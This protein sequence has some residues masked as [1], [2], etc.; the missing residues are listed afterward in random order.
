[1]TRR[2][3]GQLIERSRGLEPAV[4]RLFNLMHLMA[5]TRHC[6][7]RSKSCI[8]PRFNPC[9]S[10]AISYAIVLSMWSIMINNYGYRGDYVTGQ[11][12]C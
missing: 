8:S 4:L 11:L 6:C 7:I 1:M 3:L 10:D 2:C 9:N 5:G 12:P